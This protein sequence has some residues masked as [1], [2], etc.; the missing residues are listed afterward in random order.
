MRSTTSVRRTLLHPT[1]KE[2]GTESESDLG[3]HEEDVAVEINRTDSGTALIGTSPD[4]TNDHDTLT[5][6][7]SSDLGTWPAILSDADRCL[8]VKEGPSK[9]LTEYNFPQ[10]LAHIIIPEF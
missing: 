2:D 6:I 1:K 8:F 7:F 9:P 4:K 5:M 3:F 10:G